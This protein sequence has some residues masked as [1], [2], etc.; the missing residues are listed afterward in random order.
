MCVFFYCNGYSPDLH[1]LTLSFPTPRSASLPPAP[2]ADRQLEDPKLEAHAK[3]LMETIRCLVCQSQSIADS[4]VSMAGDMRSQIRQRILAGEKPEHVRKW[5]VER[6]GDWVSYAPPV[7]PLTWPL[8]AMP[9]LLLA[10]GLWL[11][12][13][14]FKRKTHRSRGQ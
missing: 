7:E 3:S 10:A 5:L 2:D 4:N 8:W 11:M 9:V 13:G 6:Y 12:R 14:R 1:V